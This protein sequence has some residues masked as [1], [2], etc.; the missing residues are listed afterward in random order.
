MRIAFAGTGRL[1]TSLLRGIFETRH[2]VVAIVRNGRQTRG[3]KRRVLAPVGAA[4]IGR[5]VPGMAK[6]KGIPAFYI[7]RMTDEEL[8]PLAALE[9]DLLVVGGFGIIL[10]APLLRLPKI[11]CINCHSSL[12]PKHRGPNPFSA[13]I[14]AGEDKT[15]VTFHIMDQGIDTGD[16]VDQTEVAV[17]P[18]DSAAALYFRTSAV[19]G[20]RIGVVL[21]QIATRGL[22][23]TPQDPAA[24]TYDKQLSPEQMQIDWNKPAVEID[25]LVRASMS[26]LPSFQLGHR[27]IY[28]G[29]AHPDPE[30]VDA[31]PGTVL[32]IGRFVDVATG[33][34]KLRLELCWRLKP[35]PW[36]WPG[37][38]TR[39]RVRAGDRLR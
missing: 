6:R 29:K 31:E 10:K 20:E 23:G 12:L 3:L 19:A 18:R 9:P 24:A 8:A 35:A 25:R 21:E 11:G 30:P 2:E 33:E 36:R 28:V 13:V 22:E 26:R 16:I 15:G 5:G 1:G 27:M 14:L 32:D 39:G 38:V 34:G 17:R 7:D 37:F 4:F